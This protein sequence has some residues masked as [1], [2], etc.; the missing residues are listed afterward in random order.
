MKCQPIDHATN[1]KNG[2]LNGATGITAIIIINAAKTSCW[3]LCT[4]FKYHLFLI[5][6]CYY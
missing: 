4:G 1:A 2:I 3:F 5:R 6:I